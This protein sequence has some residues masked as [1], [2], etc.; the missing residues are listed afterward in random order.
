VRTWPETAAIEDFRIR[1]QPKLIAPSLAYR[2]NTNVAKGRTEGLMGD[3]TFDRIRSIV[4]SYF[5]V[6]QNQ[7]TPV[8]SFVD[9]LETNSLDA[10]ELVLAFEDSFNVLIPDKAAEAFVTI[11]DTANYIRQQKELPLS[12]V[13]GSQ[14]VPL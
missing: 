3:D 5:G 12:D 1:A 7:V 14:T 6:D 2:K 11:Q 9:D 8:T 13:P 4:A 10:M